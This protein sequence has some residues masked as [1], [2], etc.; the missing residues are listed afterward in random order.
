MSQEMLAESLPLFR[1]AGHR[2]SD[3]I[4][5]AA[6]RRNPFIVAI[7]SSCGVQR[8]ADGTASPFISAL[9]PSVCQRSKT[10]SVTTAHRHLFSRSAGPRRPSEQRCGGNRR[11]P[12]RTHFSQLL[13]EEQITRWRLRCEEQEERVEIAL[14]KPSCRVL[15]SHADVTAARSAR[16]QGDERLG[17]DAYSRPHLPRAE[18]VCATANEAHS[19]RAGRRRI[20]TK[21]H[22]SSGRSGGLQEH[23]TSETQNTT[24]APAPL[25]V[26]DSEL[27]RALQR[28]EARIKQLEAGTVSQASAPWDKENTM[29]ASSSTMAKPQ[30]SAFPGA[31]QPFSPLSSRLETL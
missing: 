19:L 23:P 8:A 20:K 31:I 12:W 4:P 3:V 27:L 16:G 22:C 15:F 30:A 28:A 21:K 17:C 29:N 25:Y 24:S 13:S 26:R 11:L 5:A 14:A 18:L 9:A 7:G 2:S 1:A 6:Q 10:C